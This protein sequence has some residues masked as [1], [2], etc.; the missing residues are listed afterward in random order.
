MEPHGKLAGRSAHPSMPELV[1]GLE[2][3]A[4]HLHRREDAGAIEAFT[5]MLAN[6][7]YWLSFELASFEPLLETCPSPLRELGVAITL[8]FNDRMDGELTRDDLSRARELLAGLSSD[9]ASGVAEGLETLLRAVDARESR[10]RFEAEGFSI[11]NPTS[12][13]SVHSLRAMGK[14]SISV[15]GRSAT[16]KQ[17]AVRVGEAIR[18]S[19]VDERNRPVKPPEIESRLGAPVLTR[20][21]PE[22]ARSV[23][24]LVPGDYVLRVPG[25]AAGERKLRAT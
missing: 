22:G 23:I 25:R 1:G 20:D 18:L 10:P 2:L 5:R 4:A 6:A 9:L 14:A 8:R 15:F 24:F 21:E 12:A 3:S 13:L 16:D 17:L 19:A 11:Y 7:E